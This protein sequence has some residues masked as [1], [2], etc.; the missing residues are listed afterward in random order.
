MDIKVYPRSK[1]NDW[2]IVV[3]AVDYAWVW[4]RMKTPNRTI[5][6][7]WNDMT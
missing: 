7:T 4:I 1:T 5:V 2:L 3:D 6:R